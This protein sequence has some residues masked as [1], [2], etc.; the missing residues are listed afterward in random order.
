VC[1]VYL[2][3]VNNVLKVGMSSDLIRRSTELNG[4]VLYHLSLPDRPIARLYETLIHQT[5][6]QYAIGKELFNCSYDTAIAALNG[7]FRVSG[8]PLKDHADVPL[9]KPVMI[10]HSGKTIQS[11]LNRFGVIQEYLKEV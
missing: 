1:Y 3:K 4:E 11:R 8:W 7:V 5:L 6:S 2:M 9:L 10:P